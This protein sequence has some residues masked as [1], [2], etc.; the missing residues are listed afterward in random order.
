MLVI[1]AIKVKH[2]ILML[3]W[4]KECR[5]AEP[6]QGKIAWE[7]QNFVKVALIEGKLWEKLLNII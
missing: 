2:T 7:L 5:G 3:L 4:Q 1:T 6:G